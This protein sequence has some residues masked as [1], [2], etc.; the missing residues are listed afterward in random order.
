MRILLPTCL[1]LISAFLLTSCDKNAKN[2]ADYPETFM[3]P[4]THFNADNTPSAPDYTDQANWMFFP[5]DPSKYAVD[6]IWF[7]PTTFISDSLWNMPFDDEAAKAGAKTDFQNMAGIFNESCNIYAPYYRQACLAILSADTSDY[8][9][10]LGLADT[11]ANEALNYYF[12]HYN[13]GRKFIL[14]GHSQGSYHA[15]ELLKHNEK[16]KQ[17]LSNMVAAYVV[18]WSVTRTDTSDYPQL[19]ICDSSTEQ[20]CIITYNTIENGFQEEA[21]SLTLFP[22]SITVNPLLW[23]TSEELA[24][25][26]LHKGAVFASATGFDTIYNYTSAQ[27]ING[28]CVERPVNVDDF[29][30]F[31]PYFHPG[32]YHVYDYE[33]FYLNLK[34]N[35]KERIAAAIFD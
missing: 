12:D 8:N 9:A 2:A 18:G 19:N 30:V 28:L 25:R 13:K 5:E 22:N 26:T 24:P 31:E 29:V 20:G 6:L 27:N 4:K 14:A 1:A 15:L 16:L 23:N 35:V 21:A 34:E 7:N 33:F 10:A 11:D 32:I 3:G 17:H